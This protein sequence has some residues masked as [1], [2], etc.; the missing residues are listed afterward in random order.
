MPVAYQELR[1]FFGGGRYVSVQRTSPAFTSR[2]NLFPYHGK[3][4][5]TVQTYP[6]VPVPFYIYIRAVL[7]VLGIHR[8][9]PWIRVKAPGGSVVDRSLRIYLLVDITQRVSPR[10]PSQPSKPA[11]YKAVYTTYISLESPGGRGA[12]SAALKAF[13]APQKRFSSPAAIQGIGFSP[14]VA[15]AA[16]N[17]Y[18]VTPHEVAVRGS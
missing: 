12:S 15:R 16:V 6:P 18:P 8:K 7:A 11:S 3:Y 17:I 2:R 13:E 5:R 10:S 4:L 1:P 9:T 14:C